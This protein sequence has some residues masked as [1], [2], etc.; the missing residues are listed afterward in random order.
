MDSNQLVTSTPFTSGNKS[1]EKSRT[2]NVM[3]KSTNKHYNEV[4]LH[5]KENKTNQRPPLSIKLRRKVNVEDR[6]CEDME[7]L[8]KIKNATTLQNG[9]NQF[10]YVVCQEIESS[11]SFDRKQ[12]TRTYDV[13]LCEESNTN[14]MNKATNVTH[15]MLEKSIKRFEHE[16]ALAKR[17]KKYQKHWNQSSIN[18]LSKYL[19][20]FFILHYVFTKCSID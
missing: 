19:L 12:H 6:S 16:I 11:N 8:R 10:L 17:E 3:R 15:E 14:C 18:S 1:N 4:I 5:K 13:C 2:F 20:P 7:V 9:S